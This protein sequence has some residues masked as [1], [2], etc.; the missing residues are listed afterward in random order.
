MEHYYIHTIQIRAYS[1]MAK[2]ENRK[3]NR[4]QMQC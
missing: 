3:K 2:L 4:N 1:S